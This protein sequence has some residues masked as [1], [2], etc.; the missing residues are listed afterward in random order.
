MKILTLSIALLVFIA[1][2]CSERGNA[3]T[4]NTPLTEYDEGLNL[5]V[6]T[7]TMPMPVTEITFSIPKAGSYHLNVLNVT[8]YTIRSWGGT[9]SAGQVGVTWDYTNKDGKPVDVGLYIYVL[10]AGGLTARKLDL[11]GGLGS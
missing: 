1:V 9:T 11:L 7:T 2:S 10:E 8:G 4:N 5:K 3:P 6:S